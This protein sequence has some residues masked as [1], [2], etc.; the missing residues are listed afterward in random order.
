MKGALRSKSTEI[1]RAATK[2]FIMGPELPVPAVEHNLLKLND[3]QYL[4]YMATF[5]DKKVPY[6]YY[7]GSFAMILTSTA[8]HAI[9]TA[10][11][12]Y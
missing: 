6:C 9:N 11:E 8:Y 5:K 3:E 12:S 2:T 7:L 1:F 4:F 10:S